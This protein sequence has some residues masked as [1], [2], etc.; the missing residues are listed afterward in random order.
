M[1]NR[2]LISTLVSSFVSA[3]T[4]TIYNDGAKYRYI[5]IDNYI[6]FSQGVSG[7]CDSQAFSML[8]T[9]LCSDKKR[10]CQEANNIKKLADEKKSLNYE[11]SVLKELISISKPVDIDANKWIDA[12]TKIAKRKTELDIKMR[13]VG[14]RLLSASKSF[15]KQAPSMKATVSKDKCG[16][17][18]E[19]SI[20]SGYI[21]ARLLY[22]ADASATDSIKVT[23]FVA[24]NNRSGID[25]VA[26]DAYIYAKSSRV[27]L[28]PQHFNPWLAKIEKPMRYKKSSRSATK[29]SQYLLEEMRSPVG[30]ALAKPKVGTVVQTGFKNY[31]ISGLE[32]PS[33]GKDIKV[34]ISE[35]RVPAKCEYV[36][37]PYRDTNLYRLCSFAPSSAIESSKWTVKIAKR[38][39]SDQAYGEYSEGKY[40]LNTDV[41]DE[42][43]IKRKKIIKQDKSTGIFGGSIRKKDGFELDITNI[44]DKPKTFKIVERIPRSTTDKIKVKLVSV[45]GASHQ[46]VGRD[47]KLVMNI[48]LR[49]KENRKIKVLF[50]LS[51]SK[52]LSV[53]Y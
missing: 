51:Y 53:D 23:Q 29:K 18:I 2:F 45:D 33:T 26:K 8:S 38:L 17:E 25:I 41:D 47:G 40:L 19:L 5:P 35:Y 1:F 42:V 16:G 43:I 44:S 6:G 34:K 7:T 24:L 50:E 30:L 22:E 15:K 12:A 3:S 46:I 10:L 48:A 11:Y 13:S 49:A 52:D 36:V 27:Y 32:L 39:V 28:R 20:P 9:D 21:G 4:V 37:H 31:H 14:A